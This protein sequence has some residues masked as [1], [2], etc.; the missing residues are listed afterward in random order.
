MN[1]SYVTVSGNVVG[2]PV[3]RTTRASVPFVT[4][5]VASTVRRVDTKTG[6]Y[7][8]GG[9]NY[10]NVTAFR[11]RGQSQFTRVAKPQLDPH[12]RLADPAVQEAHDELARADLGD[13]PAEC[14]DLS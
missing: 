11:S 7:I 12:D 2:D 13:E 8:D 4:F 9:T 1:E 10:V 6:E 5:R 3:V 14:D